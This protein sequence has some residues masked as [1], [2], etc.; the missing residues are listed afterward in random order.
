MTISDKTKGLFVGLC[1]RDIVYYASDPL[2]AEDAKT[3]VADFRTFIG[4]PAA[5]AAITFARLGGE[6]TLVACLGGSP[7]SRAI[8]QQLVD[9]GVSVFDLA[10]NTPRTPNTSCVYVNLA[11][12]TRTIISGQAP[13]DGVLAPDEATLTGLLT[14]SA[15]C[16]YDC[17]LNAVAGS[18]AAAIAA[19]RTPLVMDCGAYKPGTEAFLAVATEVIASQAFVDDATGARGNELRDAYPNITGCAMTRGALPILFDKSD[20]STLR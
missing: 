13:L 8:A 10:A 19:S 16:L 12:G 15:F 14:G 3:K 6:A 17:N 18:L 9:L 1:G 11:R 5:N 20:E 4:G 7:E 2:P